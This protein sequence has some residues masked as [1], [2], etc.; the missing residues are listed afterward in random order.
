MPDVYPEKISSIRPLAPQ[1]VYDL[2]IEGTRNFIANGIIA[3][4][5]A[6]LP[7]VNTSGLVL[8]YHFNN[9]SGFGEND[10]NVTDFSVEVN[11]ERAGSLHNNGSIRNGAHYN[12]T[13]KILGNASMD[14]DGSDDFIIANNAK[15]SGNWTLSI[16]A[17]RIVF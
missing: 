3:H 5:T 17:K 6:K 10:T 16:W 15:T 1:H 7:Y 12:F 13:D 14:F 4:N 9:E 8:L 11:T 2:S